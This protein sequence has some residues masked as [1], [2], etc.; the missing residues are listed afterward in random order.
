[1]KSS[2]SFE[3]A[4]FYRKRERD[5]PCG[6]ILRI[7]DTRSILAF[8]RSYWQNGILAAVL[9]LV[10]LRKAKRYPYARKR[11][12]GSSW[13]F[14]LSPNVYQRYPANIPRKPIIARVSGTEGATFASH[15]TTFTSQSLSGSHWCLVVTV[16]QSHKPSWP[17]L[18]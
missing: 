5:P 8:L 12:Q 9:T 1:M 2:L 18:A 17:C 3:R 10:V 15:Y 14:K 6:F 13:T 16:G 4:E 7:V 11:S